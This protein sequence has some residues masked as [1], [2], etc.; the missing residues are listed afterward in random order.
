[1]VSY[2]IDSI[3]SDHQIGMSNHVLR[4]GFTLAA[5]LLVHPVQLAR[6]AE[7]ENDAALDVAT[8]RELRKAEKE[9]TTLC[10]GR[11][12]TP[13]ERAK[14]KADNA[15]QAAKKNAQDK[16]NK[17]KLQEDADKAAKEAKAA[18]AKEKRD[19][20]LAGSGDKDAASQAADDAQAAAAAEAKAATEDEAAAKDLQGAL[21]AKHAA[22]K[23]EAD[24]KA[25]EDAIEKEV[26]TAVPTMCPSAAPTQ[27]APTKAPTA[28]PTMPPTNAP[29]P[30]PKVTPKRNAMGAAAKAAAEAALADISSLAAET[31][32]AIGQGCAPGGEKQQMAADKKAAEALKESLKR[33][34][35]AV[36]VAE[37]AAQAAADANGA[38][39]VAA[40]AAAASKNCDDCMA[41]EEADQ[42]AMDKEFKDRNDKQ[43]ADD[44]EAARCA[45]KS[46]EAKVK[47]ECESAKV[48]REKR[49]D[50]MKQREKSKADRHKVLKDCFEKANEKA[51]ADAEKKFEEEEEKPCKKKK[52]KKSKMKLEPNFKT[53]GQ[54]SLSESSSSVAGGSD[55][56]GCLGWSP[57]SGPLEGQGARCDVFSDPDG[58]SWCYVAPGFDSKWVHK[59][60]T[61]D[62]GDKYYAP[63]QKNPTSSPVTRTV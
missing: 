63:C 33:A 51:K 18:T 2:P 58:I 39:A 57:P 40:E 37:D 1:M 52:K 20:N 46:E 6:V 17:V 12:C 50:V 19:K 42:K 60:A 59:S 48:E 55:A 15:A 30:L 35:E 23:A 10:G 34:N 36:S 38:K 43:L 53:C 9:K 27:P 29:P 5:L 13:E 54:T 41:A 25:A 3:G 62:W 31:G 28:A 7:E 45:K 11:P 26:P 16:Q 49:K 44:L 8:Q 24:L 61:S 14:E 21:A 4:R 32:C 22:E 56:S 47:Q